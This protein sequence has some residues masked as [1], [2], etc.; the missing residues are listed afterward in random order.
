[1]EHYVRA[2]APMLGLTEMNRQLPS[3]RAL[4]TVAAVII[5]LSSCS[6]SPD[7]AGLAPGYGRLTGHVGPGVP[8]AGSVPKMVLTFSNGEQTVETTAAKGT[9]T[10]D[11]PA[12]VWDARSPNGVCATGISVTAGSWHVLKIKQAGDH[13]ECWLDDTRHLDV[14]DG[15]FTAAGK[16][17]LWT[18]ADAQTRFDDLRVRGD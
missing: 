12:G 18:K 5:W 7:T 16:V 17:G 14:K 11:L 8:P 2:P 13:I 3:A 4:I 6:V 15:T 9:Y 10:F 1:M